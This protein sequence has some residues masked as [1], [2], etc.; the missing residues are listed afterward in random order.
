M[1][2]W[3]TIVTTLIMA[4]L[5]PVASAGQLAAVSIINQATGE[6]LPIWR[7]QGVNYV[8]GRPGDRYAI[9][10]RNKTDE[11][12]LS[13]L[14]VDGINV[15]TG[16]T[17]SPAQAGYVLNTWQTMEVKGWRKNMDEVA[18]FYFSQLPDS[19]AARTGRPD[20]VGVIGIALFREYVEP[21]YVRQEEYSRNSAATAQAPVPS[22]A[23]APA[24]TGSMAKRADGAELA[25]SRIGTGHGERLPSAVRST[26]FRRA[27]PMA[28][29]II[30]IR[31]D[32]YA[33]LVA[34][35]IIPRTRHDQPNPFP[36]GFVPDPD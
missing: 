13:V 17:A 4:L 25:D 35:G 32:T 9:E 2:T 31:Y 26:D 6:R 21:A 18:A 8:A 12:V 22:S 23:P 24:I 33:H 14:S 30:S 5:A 29:E 16:S 27:T 19:Y 11:R 28:N 34:R 3:I 20:N 1:K 10:I 7:H 15:L 36:G